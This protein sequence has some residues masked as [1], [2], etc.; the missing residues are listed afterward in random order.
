[1][2]ENLHDPHLHA[3]ANF[4]F[5]FAACFTVANLYYNHPILN[6]LADDFDVSY[7]RASLIPTM[8]QAG[9]AIGLVF[10]CPLGDLFKRRVFVLVLVWFTA[11]VW[12]V[13]SLQV[14]AL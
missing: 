11:T 4:L 7:E 12:Y 2:A 8:M 1:M 13:Y 9:Y 6:K 10:L 5:G 3:S 14:V